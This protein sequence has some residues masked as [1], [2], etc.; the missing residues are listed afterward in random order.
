MNDI[1]TTEIIHTMTLSV[2]SQTPI[3]TNTLPRTLEGLYHH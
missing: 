3:N 2:Y 1:D